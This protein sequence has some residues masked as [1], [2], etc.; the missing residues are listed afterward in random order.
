MTSRNVSTSN[1]YILNPVAFKAELNE[2]SFYRNDID[3]LSD[4]MV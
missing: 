4:P 3:L 1:D 2:T